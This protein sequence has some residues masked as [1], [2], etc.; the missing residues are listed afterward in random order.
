MRAQTGAVIVVSI[1]LFAAAA[2]AEAPIALEKWGRY[3]VNITTHMPVMTPP[4]GKKVEWVPKVSL[5]FKVTDPESDDVV[6]LQ[7]YHGKR[8]WGPQ[9]VCP[10]RSSQMIQRR[11]KGGKP[12]GYSLVVPVCTM[13]TKHAISQ[14]GE[15]SVVVSYKQTGAGKVHSDLGRYSYTVETY[16]SLWPGKRGPIKAYY[17]DHDFRLG[18]AWLYRNS[19]GKIEIWS[20]FKFDR[21]GEQLVR[22]G[23]MRCYVGDAKLPFA[24]YAVART[25]NS[26]QHYAKPNAPSKVTWGLYYWW[27]ARTDGVMAWD[28][29]KEHP[30]AYRCTLT[31]AGDIAREFTFQVA[32]GEIQRA[33]CQGTTGNEV[34]TLADEFLVKM[35]VKKSHDLKYDKRA[36]RRSG[37][38]GRKWPKGCPL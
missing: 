11:G 34:K 18:E 38:Y 36:F 20:W 9:Q 2:R 27:A 22:D 17:V 35:K 16:N 4:K 21:E 26:Y 24:D 33:P 37:L 1:V 12:M 28:W 7:H 5:V 32:D 30:G 14:A 15:F 29:M 13:E 23:R 10:I 19:E 8:K 25:T 31:Q 3:H 6:L